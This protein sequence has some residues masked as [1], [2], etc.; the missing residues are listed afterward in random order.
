M[1]FCTLSH[2]VARFRTK[3]FP[4]KGYD[5]HCECLRNHAAESCTGFRAARA[6]DSALLSISAAWR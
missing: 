6:P 4:A 3:L 1:A 2:I 5:F